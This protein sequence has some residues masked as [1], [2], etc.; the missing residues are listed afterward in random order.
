MTR[1]LIVITALFSFHLTG[2]TV[3]AEMQPR[4]GMP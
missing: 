2:L 3:T 1:L 4:I